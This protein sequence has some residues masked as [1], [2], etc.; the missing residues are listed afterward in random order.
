[1]VLYSPYLEKN[2]LLLFVRLALGYL[3]K[4]DV[5]RFVYVVNES[6]DNL[7]FFFMIRKLK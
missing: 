6:G 7:F 4:K 2:N 1:M 5:A 3:I